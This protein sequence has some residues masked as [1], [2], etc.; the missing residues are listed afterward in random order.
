MLHTQIVLGP[1]DVM[2]L[3]F[4]VQVNGRIIDCA[5]TL[6]WDPMF[7]ALVEAPRAATNAGI[8]V[9]VHTPLSGSKAAT[10]CRLI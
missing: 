2:K 7:D 10:Q 4:G 3:D 1:K 9:C 6:H 5:M 8:K